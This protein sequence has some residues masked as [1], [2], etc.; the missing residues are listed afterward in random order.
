MSYPHTYIK[1][2]EEERKGVSAELK[3]LAIIGKDKERKRLQVVWLSDSGLTFEQI[4]RRL[5]K[6][7][8]TVQRWVS[9]YRK[10]GLK[11]FGVKHDK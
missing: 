6:S 11:A 10:E 7:Y 4:A 2:T 1:L 9:K 5:G 8:R 3:R